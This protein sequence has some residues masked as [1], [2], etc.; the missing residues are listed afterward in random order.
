MKL[1]K[2][3]LVDRL[4]ALESIILFRMMM[5]CVLFIIKIMVDIGKLLRVISILGIWSWAYLSDNN[6]QDESQRYLQ[7]YSIL[8]SVISLIQGILWNLV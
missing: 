1:R 7:D 2:E 3:L 4:F 5:F 8:N 6:K